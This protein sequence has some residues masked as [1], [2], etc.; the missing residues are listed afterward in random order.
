MLAHVGQDAR[1]AKHEPN[2]KVETFL[3]PRVSALRHDMAILDRK[4]LERR[5]FQTR[6]CFDAA[7]GC[8]LTDVLQAGRGRCRLLCAMG[9]SNTMAYQALKS[10]CDTVIYAPMLCVLFL[11]TRMRAL[12]ITQGKGDPP[13]FAQIAMQVCTWAV[14]IQTSLALAIPLFTGQAA[15]LDEDGNVVADGF[16]Q[17]STISLE[18]IE[19]KKVMLFYM[20]LIE[21]HTIEF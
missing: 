6:V 10:A 1:H 12:Q 19:D 9:I 11:G 4:V 15:Q 21:I 20:T 16:N 13:M 5:C 17:S 18:F 7:S 2:I 3:P 8:E 14:L